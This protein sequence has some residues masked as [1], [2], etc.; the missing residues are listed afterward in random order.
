VGKSF[1]ILILEEPDTEDYTR[2]IGVVS[3]APK[4]E[5]E[6]QRVAE[7]RIEFVKKHL[8]D[9]EAE[10]SNG[11]KEEIEIPITGGGGKRLLTKDLDGWKDHV[12]DGWMLAASFQLEGRWGAEE[13]ETL[14]N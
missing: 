10:N 11:E 1:V 13:Q 7:K 14:K 2:F 6:I 3:G 12:R 8:I 4:N 9:L 5:F